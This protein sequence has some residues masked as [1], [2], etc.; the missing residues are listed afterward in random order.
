MRGGS[1]NLIGL[2]VPEISN[3]FYSTIAQSL[4]QVCGRHNYRVVLSLTG[5]DG[6]NEAKNIRELV[7]AQAAGLIIVPAPTTRRASLQ[8]L[9]QIPHVQ[10]LR[11]VSGLDKIWFGIDDRDAITEAVEHLVSLGHRRI[12]YIGGSEALSTGVERREGFVRGCRTAG[13]DLADCAI[14]TGPPERQLGREAF[15]TLLSAKRAP[16]AIV[17][18]AFNVAI[19]IIECVEA[20]G[21][22]DIPSVVGFGD[23]DWFAWWRGGLTTIRPPIDNLAT[24]CALWFLDQL[25]DRQSKGLSLVEHSSV[26]AST[27]IVRASSRPVGPGRSVK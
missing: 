27:L 18:G 13:L 2:L 14:H 8:L 24:S 1:N 16:T 12:A 7:A 9:K 3:D 19:G 22:T 5:D 6:D 11:K 17:A 21:L 23:P 25:G 4:S 10:L 15:D 26:V 20:R